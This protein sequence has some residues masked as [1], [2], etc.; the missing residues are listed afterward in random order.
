MSATS[1]TQIRVSAPGKLMLLGE[2]AVVHHRPCLVTAMDAR[3]YLKL[4]LTEPGDDTFT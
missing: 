3:L 1:L 2:H 4:E